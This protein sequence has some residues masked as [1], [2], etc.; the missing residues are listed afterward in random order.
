MAQ[1]KGRGREK[2]IDRQDRLMMPTSPRRQI[3]AVA[4]LVLLVSGGA[5]LARWTGA[6][7]TA[8]GGGAQV[9]P[10]SLAPGSPSK[11]YIYAGSR[12]VATEEPNGAGPGLD[13]IGLYNPNDNKYYLRNSNTAGGHDLQF[14]YEGAAGLTPITGDWNG[15]G[16]DTVGLYD[17][18]GA[19]F[20]L[21]NSNTGGTADITFTYG[22]AGAGLVP[23]AG[24]WNGDGVDSIGLHN[25]QFA[26]FFLRNSNTG[27]VADL[28]FNYGEAGGSR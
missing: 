8:A 1:H 27:G 2:R 13:T 17:P 9:T 4:S 22:G 7:K 21:R 23:L 28:M 6:L 12:L 5:G 25:P 10:P 18:A 3:I 20:F 11:E 26:A 15:D 14:E 16:V 19:A 24:D